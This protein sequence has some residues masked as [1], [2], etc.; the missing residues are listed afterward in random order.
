MS[1][2]T[3]IVPTRSRPHRVRPMINAWYA[4]GAFDDGADLQFVIDS[5]DPCLDQYESEIKRD[6]LYGTS[7]HRSIAPIWRP[8]VPKLNRTALPLAS[9]GAPMLGFLGDDHEPRSAGWAARVIE[10]LAE[11][12]IVSGPDGFRSDDLPTWWAMSGQIIEELGVMV[13]GGMAHLYCDNAVRDLATCSGTYRW[14]DGV[15]IEHMHPLAG[16]ASVDDQYTKVNSATQ[17]AADRAAYAL[18]AATRMR[19]DAARVI[20]LKGARRGV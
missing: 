6:A 4:T 14:L 20:S 15:L 2:L 13:P 12:G 17:Y 3:M 19:D 10:A 16:K 9:F 5:D 18:W 8:L 11:I 7:I 1:R